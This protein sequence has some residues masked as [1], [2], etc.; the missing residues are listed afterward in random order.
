MVAGFLQAFGPY[1]VCFAT[2]KLAP[3][4]TAKLYARVIE[5]HGEILGE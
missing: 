1:R 5:S 4:A 3:K 2:Q